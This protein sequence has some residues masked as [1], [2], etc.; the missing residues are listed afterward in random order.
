MAGNFALPSTSFNIAASKFKDLPKKKKWFGELNYTSVCFRACLKNP[1]THKYARCTY[2]KLKTCASWTLSLWRTR[3]APSLPFATR[4]CS[5]ACRLILPWFQGE[6]ILI[7][8][9]P[10]AVLMSGWNSSDWLLI[11]EITESA[12]KWTSNKNA[13]THAKHHVQQTAFK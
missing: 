6:D 3:K 10:T 1:K 8:Q 2:H 5:P 11:L 7:V 12:G 9:K 13:T 4:S